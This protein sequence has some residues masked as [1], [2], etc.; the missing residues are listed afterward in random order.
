MKREARVS[1]SACIDELC[2]A[3]V[4]R[5]NS[6][7]GIALSACGCEGLCARLREE[8]YLSEVRY[9]LGP[10]S[11]G[12]AALPPE[13]AR[14][15]GWAREFA[16]KVVESL[17]ELRSARPELLTCVREDKDGAGVPEPGQRGRA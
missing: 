12:V 8:G 4:V 1:A 6:I 14:D 5:L 13:K 3:V 16:A 10:C 15:Y 7:D 9:S 2:S 11:C 17:I